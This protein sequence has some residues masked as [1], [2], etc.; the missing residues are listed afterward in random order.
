MEQTK[1]KKLSTYT[2]AFGVYPHGDN[3][4]SACVY[5]FKDGKISEW[6]HGNG[7]LLG[8]AIAIAEE[9]MSGYALYAHEIKAEDFYNDAV[10]I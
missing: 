4:F 7:T 10:I 2:L 6:K 1:E 5:K 3:L 8:H 9:L